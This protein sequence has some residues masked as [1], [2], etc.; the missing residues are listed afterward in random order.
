MTVFLE[1]ASYEG[2]HEDVSQAM[3][4]ENK[5][6]LLLGII[7]MVAYINYLAQAFTSLL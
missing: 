6:K 5:W 1:G 3:L 2:W 4:A 7:L